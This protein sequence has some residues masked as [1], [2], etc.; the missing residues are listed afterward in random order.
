MNDGVITF[1]EL[2]Q[3]N[4]NWQNR[5]YQSVDDGST[6]EWNSVLVD[7]GGNRNMQSIY[8]GFRDKFYPDEN[9]ALEIWIGYDSSDYTACTHIF[10]LDTGSS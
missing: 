6:N 5:V 9:I 4:T 10:T 8:L 3:P 2:T 7:L 1:I